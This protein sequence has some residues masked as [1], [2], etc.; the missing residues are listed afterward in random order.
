MLTLVVKNDVD[1]KARTALLEEVKK[2]FGSLKKEDLW[3]A[4]SLAYP[5]MHQDRAY[6]AHF[7]FESEPST[8]FA[9]DKMV[10]LNEDII[11]YLLTRVDL[12]K[13]AAKPLFAGKKQVTKVESKEETEKIQQ[14]G[15]TK[16]E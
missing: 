5:I 9:L 1:E 14:D 7:E 8:I 4:R 16:L 10:K 6:F 12:P 11:R 13:K 15:D 2:Q 3:G